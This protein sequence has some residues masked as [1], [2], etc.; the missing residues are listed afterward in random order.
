[1]LRLAVS[2]ALT[3]ATCR[4]IIMIALK[5]WR[6]HLHLVLALALFSSSCGWLGGRGEEPPAPPPASSARPTGTA[7]PTPPLA[8][9]S[10]ATPQTP[11]SANSSTNTQPPPAQPAQAVNASAAPFSIPPDS[12]NPLPIVS[13]SDVPPPPFDELVRQG[14][15]L[16]PFLLGLLNQLDAAQFDLDALNAAHSFDADQLLAFMQSEIKFE[17]YPGVLR[18][19]QGTLI[20]RAGSALDQALLL[21]QLLDSAGYETRLAR[22]TLTRPQAETLLAQMALPRGN[23]PAIG[24]EAAVEELL[25]QLGQL[26]QAPPPTSLNTAE[27][28]AE[29]DGL[30][31]ADTTLILSALQE[32]GVSFDNP[33]P[34]PEALISEGQDY[35]WVQYRLSSFDDWQDA[36]PAFSNPAAAPAGLTP[37][38]TFREGPPA[39]LYHRFRLEIFVEQ[40][41]DEEL[42]VHPLLENW[43]KTAAELYGRSITFQNQP[44]RLDLETAAS[45]DPL[46][47][48]IGV[49]LPLVNNELTPNAFDLDGRIFSAGLVALDTAGMTELFQAT[50]AGVETGAGAIGSLGE[51]DAGNPDDLF[52]LTAQWLEY[53]LI[54]PDGR[55]QTTRRY[56]LDRIGEANREAGLA[57][58]SDNT[59]LQQSARALLTSHTIMVLPGEYGQPYAA[60]RMLTRTLQELDVL[61]AVDPDGNLT[62]FPA[63]QVAG[64]LP[65]QDVI[66]NR[67]L[68]NGWLNQPD[69]RS[70]R[71]APTLAIYQQGLL[72]DRPEL[73]AFERVD[74]IHNSRRVFTVDDGLLQPDPAAAV[75]QGVWETLA[76]RALIQNLG[77]EP[78][79]ALVSLRAAA[80]AGI[81]LQVIPPGEEAAL[82]ALPHL[83]ATIDAARRDLAAGYVVIIPQRPHDDSGQSGWWRVDP[84]TGE[85]LGMATGGYGQGYV[86]Y[87]I[88]LFFGA[89][90]FI[91]GYNNCKSKGG[92]T[93]CCL[94]ENVA[95]LTIGLL[96]GLAIG[97][98]AFVGGLSGYTSFGLGFLIGDMGMGIGFMIKPSTCYR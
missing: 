11:S 53:T 6:F 18:G 94:V 16:R 80:A 43:E 60:Q 50:A 7:A 68:A 35:F 76:E 46:L 78:G 90:F 65:F 5:K 93:S 97:G 87:L 92:S 9:G 98:I 64:L 86:E 61:A 28:A 81:P 72:P 21:R 58:I 85:T 25:Q 29:V 3:Q 75:R 77:A 55:E 33:G 10:P 70:Y 79:G 14:E 41:F 42:R 22:T 1:M 20:G 12:L 54:S 84:H 69:L 96:T 82:A 31:T 26:G 19:P 57:E 38:E 23:P 74:I 44:N 15:Q 67:A 37:E 8:A 63:Q 59:P 49:F 47:D 95:W 39:D 17:Q 73:T 13:S 36:Q 34:L 52:T 89:I 32:A 66:L 4:E 51:E 56:I 88:S 83:P 45:I 2:A 24:D 27:L 71:A 48:G 62:D 91:A 30:T 40:K